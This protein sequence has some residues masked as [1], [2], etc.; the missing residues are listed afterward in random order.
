MVSLASQQGQDV[1]AGVTLLDH[2]ADV[3]IVATGETQGEALAWAA[4]GMFSVIANLE[5]VLPR[6]SSTIEVT[7]TDPE[8]LA[9]DWLNELLYRYEAEDFLP[10]QFQVSV[11]ETKTSLTA[12]CFGETF[13]PD[14]H[15]LL[16]SVKAATYHRLEVVHDSEWRIQVIL[17]V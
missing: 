9:V 13:D 16:T 12:T 17:D 10:C 6:D 14:R 4:K 5:D 7:S 3:G 2:T 11:D 1:L 15:L 8:T